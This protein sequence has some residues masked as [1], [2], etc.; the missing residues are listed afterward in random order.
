MEERGENLHLGVLEE[1]PI[2][3]RESLHVSEEEKCK[4]LSYWVENKATIVEL[5]KVFNRNYGTI[6][7]LLDEAIEKEKDHDRQSLIDEIEERGRIESDILKKKLLSALV[8]GIY[9]GDFAYVRFG[10]MQMKDSWAKALMGGKG[11]EKPEG[12]EGIE[13]AGEAFGE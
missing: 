11:K 13:G 5:T 2:E 7:K 12:S 4:I 6:R 8:N 10:L 9:E 3:V 1:S